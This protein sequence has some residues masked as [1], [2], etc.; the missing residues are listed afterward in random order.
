[1]DPGEAKRRIHA[2]RI[3]RDITQKALDAKAVEEWGM[4]EQELSRTERGA[5]PFSRPRQ[6][7]F[8]HFLN[9]PPA[10]FGEANLD[11]LLGVEARSVHEETEDMIED[12]QLAQE[13]RALGDFSPS[14]ALEDLAQE[15]EGAAQPLGSE[16]DDSEA[17]EPGRGSAGR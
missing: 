2:A 3:L 8:E 7:A 16:S 17:D 5:L 15:T 13:Q 4:D 9:L 12:H 14:S 11:R 10:W 1:M 6:L